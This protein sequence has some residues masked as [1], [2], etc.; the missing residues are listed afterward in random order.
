MTRSSRRIST[1]V[2]SFTGGILAAVAAL[3]FARKAV[4]TGAP[5]ESDMS[6]ETVP[7]DGG[8]DDTELELLVSYMAGGSEDWF[9]DGMLSGVLPYKVFESARCADGDAFVLAVGSFDGEPHYAFIHGA[10]PSGMEPDLALSLERLREASEAA[11]G[12]TVSL[13]AV[14][15]VSSLLVAAPEGS[16]AQ[17]QVHR[18][19]VK[20]MR[21]H[22]EAVDDLASSDVDGILAHVVS[23][24]LFNSPL[25]RGARAI[26]ELR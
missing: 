6:A 9:T 4:T 3:S 5:T 20:L 8:L 12:D 7:D 22:A 26:R 17:E 13:H 18:I 25:H 21:L 10:P 24:W 11:E 14:A 2:A 16:D 1:L 19:L 23:G 15:N